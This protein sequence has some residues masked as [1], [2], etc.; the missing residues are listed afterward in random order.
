MD[1][2]CVIVAVWLNGRASASYSTQLVPKRKVVGSSPMMVVVF[3]V[4]GIHSFCFE[5]GV[6]GNCVAYSIIISMLVDGRID[7]YVRSFF[8]FLVLGYRYVRE[9]VSELQ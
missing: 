5:D 1:T 7:E 3:V 2:S 8:F 9:Y 4:A 6:I